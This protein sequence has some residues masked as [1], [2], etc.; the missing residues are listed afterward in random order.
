MK[1]IYKKAKINDLNEIEALVKN[2]V[3]EMEHNGIMQW[4]EMYPVREDFEQDIKNGQLY[5]G[6]INDQIAVIFTLNQDC[7][8]EYK[9]G[10]WKEPERPFYI[11]H[12]LCVH[13]EYQKNGIAMDAMQF[14][15]CTVVQDG[16]QAIRLDAYSLNP[17]ALK[18]YHRSGYSKVGKAEWRKGTFYLMEK[19]LV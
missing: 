15:E 5:A 13:P 9:N 14:I 17:Y 7:D 4:D 19:Y 8:E 3:I 18:L 11:I 16:A 6:C 1:L 12:R 10:D 2:A